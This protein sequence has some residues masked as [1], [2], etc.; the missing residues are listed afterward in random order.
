MFTFNTV[1]LKKSIFSQNTLMLCKNDV[2]HPKKLHQNT[3]AKRNNVLRWQQLN[4]NCRSK[5]CSVVSAPSNL[6]FVYKWRSNLRTYVNT[7]KPQCVTS[8]ITFSNKDNFRT[9]FISFEIVN[10]V[11]C[12]KRA[13]NEPHTWINSV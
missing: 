3:G 8:A 13:W 9:N 6:C 2:M 1:Q 10:I 5:I 12:I 11:L 7:L 4:M